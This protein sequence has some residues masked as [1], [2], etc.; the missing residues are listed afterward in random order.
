MPEGNSFLLSATFAFYDYGDLLKKK[1][2]IVQLSNVLLT[3]RTNSKLTL[4]PPLSSGN[5]DIGN[6]Y[7]VHKFEEMYSP[8][9]SYN[10]K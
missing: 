4:T 6:H 1:K 7:S 8:F 10:R 2:K 3:W 9:I 5:H